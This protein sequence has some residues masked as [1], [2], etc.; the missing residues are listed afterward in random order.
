ML[1]YAS[2]VATVH[3]V[4]T[5][6]I[7]L[8]VVCVVGLSTVTIL[9]LMGIE[10]LFLGDGLELSHLSALVDKMQ[11]L[12]GGGGSDDGSSSLDR[13][14]SPVMPLLAVVILSYSVANTVLSVFKTAIDTL[15]ICFCEDVRVNE[16]CGEYFMSDQLLRLIEV[17][18]KDESFK[19]FLVDF[20]DQTRG[21]A[22]SKE[23]DGSLEAWVTVQ[24]A[25][26]RE[27]GRPRPSDATDPSGPGTAGSEESKPGAGGGMMADETQAVQAGVKKLKTGVGGVAAGLSHGLSSI[28]SK[29]K[30]KAK[31]GLGSSSSSRA[32]SGSFD[33][34][35][36]E[37][38][39]ER[40]VI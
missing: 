28:A 36:Q 35:M 34:A 29:A 6:L 10:V 38:D 26:A 21:A 14:S 8:G 17:K 30:E 39:L 31:A 27:E 25:M 37:Q 23:E 13:L 18:A 40:I 4:A 33:D 24:E 16:D 12:R 1:R 22:A 9:S 15:L 11:D 5:V 32:R 7:R 19:R 3:I 2:K 20:Q